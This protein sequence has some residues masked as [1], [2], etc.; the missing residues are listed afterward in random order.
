[1]D[2]VGFVEDDHELP[3][4]EE[5]DGADCGTREELEKDSGPAA[6][7]VDGAPARGGGEGIVRSHA[8]TSTRPGEELLRRGRFSRRRGSG[9]V[10]T[11]G[12]RLRGRRESGASPGH[13]R[14]A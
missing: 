6:A 4:T 14:E 12:A 10:S 1:M 2:F 7:E 9:L 11:A 13:A 5:A 3:M 8:S